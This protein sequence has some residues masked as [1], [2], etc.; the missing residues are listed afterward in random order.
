MLPFSANAG[1]TDPEEQDVI[2]IPRLESICRVV[3]DPGAIWC[4]NCIKSSGGG[5]S[6]ASCGVSDA[7]FF[8]S[9][10][11]EESSRSLRKS[12]NSIIISLIVCCAWSLHDTTMLCSTFR[13]S[14]SSVTSTIIDDDLSMRS[15]MSS[16]VYFT[17]L[18][19]FRGS[20]FVAIAFT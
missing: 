9:M 19:F 14:S 16:I 1:V 5:I 15:D 6:G 3:I 4:P 11:S 13:C 10:T 17:C 7:I 2:E 8:D 12:L 20:F 18:P